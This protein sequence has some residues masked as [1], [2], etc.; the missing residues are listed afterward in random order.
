M[1]A[2]EPKNSAEAGV[3]AEFAALVGARLS[4]ILEHVSRIA[5]VRAEHARRA[6][7]R[8]AVGVTLAAGAG[9]VLASVAIFASW[10]L[11]RGLSQGLAELTG[12]P[13][14]GELSC[15]VLLLAVVFGAAAL[16]L[17][18][19][20]PGNTKACES[21]EAK[22]LEAWTGLKESAAEL[23]EDLVRAGKLRERV[24]EHPYVALG[25]GLAA[26][27]AVAPLLQGLLKHTGPLARGA[28][29]G[30]PGLGPIL[31][32]AHGRRHPTSSAP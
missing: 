32:Q 17:A 3:E 9:M 27:I 6:F 30:V 5:E 2:P 14:L 11:A 15:G 8:K 4:T 10:Q 16:A 7:L 25:A 31:R 13:W 18:R 26:G 21:L 20:G 28:L 29:S 19:F 1:I 24:R 23:G 12:K 22:E